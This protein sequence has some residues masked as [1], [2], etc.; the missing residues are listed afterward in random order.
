MMKLCAIVPAHNEEAAISDVVRGARAHAEEVVVV[1]DGSSDATAS[2]AEEAGATVLR[3][4]RKSGKGMA[5][6]AGFAHALRNDFDAVITLD[7]DGQHDP[8]EIPRFVRCAERRGVSLVTGSRM[9]NA[10]GMPAARWFFNRITSEALSFALRHEIR[11]SQ[12]G[13]RLLRRSLLEKL[14]LSAKKYD[15]ETEVLVQASDHGVRPCEIPIHC[16]YRER[17]HTH[18]YPDVMRYLR[19][20]E[21]RGSHWRF[22]WHLAKIAGPTALKFVAL[23]LLV[24]G[25]LLLLLHVG[26]GDPHRIRDAL[27]DL[28]F[29]GPVLFVILCTL[30]PLTFLPFSG[31]TLVAGAAFGLVSGTILVA[32]GG[33]T[34]AVVG[35]MMGRVYLRSVVERFLARRF[36][37]ADEWVARGG[38]S[39]IFFVRLLNIPWDWVS[40]AAGFSKIQFHEFMLGTGAAVIPVAFIGTF[41]GDSL[42]TFPSAQFFTAFGILFGFGTVTFL[43]RRRFRPA[44]A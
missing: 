4:S 19:I 16:V 6:R 15:I 25:A 27:A 33:M 9:A 28:G 3:L 38:W 7:A 31:L 13:Y 23:P 44:A 41:F 26:G 24:I 12:C 10:G 42:W 29:L 1:D 18:G 32:I 11:D 8:A 39:S 36:P 30:K 37:G 34:G 40:Y 5:L 43:V 22:Y 21:R 20:V 17:G 14:S 2:R 35:F